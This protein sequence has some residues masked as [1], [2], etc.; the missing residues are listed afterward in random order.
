MRLALTLLLATAI[1]SPAT[2]APR[3][4]GA[5]QR[6]AR[7]DDLAAILADLQARRP[8]PKLRPSAAMVMRTAGGSGDDLRCLTEA[9]YFEARGEPA[10]GQAAVAQVVLNRRGA[11]GF[12][13]TVC[14]VIYES[15]RAGRCQFSF[16]CDGSL[17]RGI[18]DPAAWLR[19]ET[20]A[21]AALAGTGEAGELKATHF[22]ADRIRPFWAAAFKRVASLGRHV[23]YGSADGA[24]G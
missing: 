15:R 8:K 3:A 10:A 4:G 18:N 11:R 24:V 14:G 21:R 19:A 16:A 22:H 2:A 1:A 7:A 13:K 9:V 17:T 23:F 5:I 20:V 12:P 6:D